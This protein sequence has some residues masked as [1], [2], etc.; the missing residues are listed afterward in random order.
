MSDKQKTAI[1]TGCTGQDGSY[2]SEI[3]LDKGYRV[4]GIHRRSSM[5]DKK[6]YNVSH[7]VDNPNF[8]LEDGDLT[9]SSS[10]WRLVSKYMP[11]EFYNLGAQSHVGVSFTSPESTTEINA[12]GV[13]NCLEAIRNV[14]PKTK[15]YQASTSEMFGDN[16]NVPQSETTTFQPNS[17]YACAK[18][19]AHNLVVNYRKAYGLFACSGI[20]FNHET[21]SYGMPLIIKK[22]NKIDIL[23]IGDVARFHTGVSFDMDNKTYQD[24]EPNTDIQIWDKSG[25]V[26]VKWVSGYPHK[27]DKNPRVINARNYS[28]TATGNHPCIMEDDSEIKTSDLK[29]GDKVKNIAYP[30]TLAQEYV[31]LEEAEWLGMMVGDGNLNH[32]TPR[33]TNK[34]SSLKE[35][36]CKLWNNFTG[37]HVKYKD[38]YSGFTGEYIGQVECFS[39]LKRDYDIYTNDISPFGH[40]NKKVPAKILNSTKDVM[41]AFLDG[42]NACDGLKKNPC[43]YKYRNFKTNSA[44]LAAGL[45]FLISKVTGQKYNITVEES[46]KHGEQ[47]FYYS[48]NLLTDRKTNLQKYEKVNSMFKAGKTSRSIA[49]DTKI[50]RTFIKKIKNGYIPEN[51]HHLE[52]CSNEIK[53]IIEIPEYSGWFFDLETTSGTFHAGVGQG[54]VHNSPRRGEQ[55]VTR[56][57]TKAA[58][59]IKLGLQKELRLGNL[60]AKRDWGYAKEYVYGMWLMLQQDTPDDYV[61]ATGKTSTIG[62]FIDCVSEVAGFDLSKH[63]VV[64][65]KYLRPSEVPL[66]LGDP[67]KA[68]RILGWEARTTLKELAQIMYENDLKDQQ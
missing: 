57:I 64:D 53:K 46:N 19:Y 44:T 66:L 30:E 56:K 45:L 63:V 9:D 61:L 24:G 41:R 15:F 5:E 67:S 34:D 23:P 49:R 13:L 10:I 58:A 12:T 47:Q 50:S 29:I 2:L 21:L 40:K 31:S 18:V 17:P 39:D 1:I 54:V 33:F 38:S 20:L 6:L 22:N 14:S 36:F 37:G 55:F 48:I 27:Q 43:K 26:G 25:W 8:I 35:H 28:Y 62:Q 7:L 42:Y 60:D 68:K 52:Q 4:V 32:N 51:T 65:E 3:L 59:R 11:D 16:M